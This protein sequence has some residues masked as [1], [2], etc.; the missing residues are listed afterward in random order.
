MSNL[1][2]ANVKFRGT[3]PLLYHCFTEEAI[4]LVKKEK[5]GV[6]GNNPDEWRTTYTVTEK[7][8]FYLKPDYIFSSLRNGAKYTT[9]GRGT[10]QSKVAA[11]LQ[12]KDEIILLNRLLKD[13]DSIERDSTKPVY[14]DVSPVRISATKGRHLRYRVALSA[15]WEGQFNIIW[16]KTIVSRSEMERVCIDAGELEGLGD[17]RTIGF[18]RFEILKFSVSEYRE[19]AKIEAS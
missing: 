12:V 3:K 4:P 15:G 18:G 19:N 17:G 8:Q 6:A 13:P 9:K 5:N 7:G 10:I 1:L 14:L 2:I 11:T 16:N